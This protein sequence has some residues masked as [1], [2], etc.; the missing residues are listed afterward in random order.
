MTL[1]ADEEMAVRDGGAERVLGLAHVLAL[2]LGEH[3][4]DHQRALAAPHVH[5]DLEVLPGPHRLAVEVPR[6]LGR[7]HAAEQHP[8]HGAVAVRHRLVAQRHR[9]PRRLLLQVCNTNQIAPSFLRSKA[10]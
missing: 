5:V 3:L 9:K 1:T 8:E 2:V 7:R 6:H 10:K 4:D